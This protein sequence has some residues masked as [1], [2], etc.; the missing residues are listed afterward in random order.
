MTSQLRKPNRIIIV[1]GGTAGWM[2]ANLMVKAWAA[3]GIQI[4]LIESPDIGII[5]V[6]EGSTPQLKNF[7][8]EI[9]VTES[10]WM[11][12]CNATYKTGIT[13]KGWSS[14][15]GFESYFHPFPG[16]L[17]VHTSQ[18]FFYNT[19]IRRQGIDV[20][21][22]PDRFFV[23]AKL[24]A[25]QKGPIPND[26]FPFNVSYG[27]HFDSYLVGTFLQEL[28]ISKGV[29]HLQGKI[30]EVKLALSGD[31]DSLV[32][33]NG[34][35]IKADFFV[36]C[37]GFNSIL[38]QKALKVEF[39]NFSDNLFN[40]RA[41]VL[42]TRKQQN[43]NSQTISTTMNCGWAW[44]IPLQNRTGNGYVYSSDFCTKDEAE[45]ELRQKLG[46]LDSEVEARHLKMR[47]G[48][49]NT[50]WFK[51]CVAIGL[52]QGFI[53]PLE[54]T[55]L[56]LVHSSIDLFIR[57]FE[58]GKWS[59]RYQDRF[60][61]LISERF[62]G[63]RNYI[64]AHYRLNSRTDT[65]YW[66]ANAS[67]ENLSDSLKDILRCWLNRNDLTKEI[68]RQGIDKYYSPTSWH[69]LLAGY[70]VFPHQEQLTAAK[71]NLMKYDMQALDN[72]VFKSASHY[73]AH[74]AQLELLQTQ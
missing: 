64:V 1:G 67:N 54:A 19:F 60:N 65:D 73:S 41:V 30:Y 35:N 16:D 57:K 18:Q 23:Q 50:H 49:V 46:M 52:A 53:E 69:C 63:I 29:E 14:K 31:I 56:H 48:Q 21:G 34:E 33:T 12:K 10:Q 55:A 15:P 62:E 71:Q 5:G 40:D 28:A 32:L 3:K 4:T 6:G 17:D 43:P 51:N 37:S 11:P 45:S 27:Y 70:G 9:G 59:D 58:E 2:C 68:L 26:N 38:L 25:L 61:K 66:K 42:P 22:H 44:D 24:A 8:D 36:D 74:L 13:F 39:R 72:F 47:V 20:H 7:F